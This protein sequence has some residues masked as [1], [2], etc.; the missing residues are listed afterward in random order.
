MP[1]SHIK[2]SVRLLDTGFIDDF[3]IIF[4]IYE[5]SVISNPVS[6]FSK[7]VQRTFFLLSKKNP[8]ARLLKLIEA[9]LL[10]LHILQE[11]TDPLARLWGHSEP[12]AFL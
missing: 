8:S 6:K 3:W 10:S 7:N 1:I 2:P 12:L 9:S 4:P 11:P 5:D